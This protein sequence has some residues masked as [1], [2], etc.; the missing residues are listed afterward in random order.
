MNGG[1]KKNGRSLLLFLSVRDP[2]SPQSRTRELLLELSM[3]LLVF[4]SGFGGCVTSRW[5]VPREN[6][7]VTSSWV[8]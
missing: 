2:V 3:S 8:Q 7:M 4:P 6:K 5:E 1:K